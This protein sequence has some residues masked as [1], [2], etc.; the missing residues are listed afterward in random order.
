MFEVAETFLVQF[1]GLFPAILGV[2]LIF[3]FTGSLIF[4]RK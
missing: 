4:G 2:W 3:D 1:V